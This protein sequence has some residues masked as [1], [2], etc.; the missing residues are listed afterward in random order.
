MASFL[1]PELTSAAFCWRVERRDGVCLGFT[2][3]DRDLVVAHLRYRAA[4]GLLP[5]AV[6][7]SDGFGS[8][9]LDISGALTSDAISEAD[10]SA[11]R[12]DGAAVTLFM[13]DWESPGSETLFLARGRL[14]DVAFQGRRFSAEL[15]GP[16]AVLDAPVVE[17]TSP[18]CRASLGDRRCRVDL[19]PRSLV[20]RI[21]AVIEEDL[22]E[23]DTGSAA[24][25]AYAY[26]RARWISGANSGLDY[27]VLSSAG[28]S[29]TLRE[30]PHFPCAA[31]DLIEITEGC[32]KR[33]QTC[34][35]RFG[36]AANFRG[37][38]HLPGIDLL[39]RYPGAQ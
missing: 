5:S 24:A 1:Q 25:N 10:L 22:I 21:T 33:L 4:P 34:I 3:H 30:P 26:G 18:G 2:T 20:T 11:G 31:G 28:R 38:P 17:Q 16:T 14:G 29:L 37:E 6:T 23:V 36:N 27:P 8:G 9:A 19:A 12:W 15:R 32:D 7:L 39:T 13:V 35:G